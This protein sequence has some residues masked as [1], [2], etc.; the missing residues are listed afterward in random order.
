MF[1]GTL[2][3]WGHPEHGQLGHNSEGSYLERAGKVNFDF[4]YTP[5]KVVLFVEKDPRSKAS[6]PVL[7]VSIKDVT[8]GINHT[9]SI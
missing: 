1:L 9:V 4:V 7:G 2:W 5:T 3:T 8:C 6:T